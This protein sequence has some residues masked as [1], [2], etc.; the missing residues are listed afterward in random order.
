MQDPA[1]PGP[2]AQEPGPETATWPHRLLRSI[3]TVPLAIWIFL[4]EWVWDSILAL[5]RWAG[6]LPPIH[7]LE[8][9]VSK[10]PPYAAL[11]AF[12]VPGLTLLPFKFAALYLIAHGHKLYGV[13]VFIVAKLIGTA[14]LARIFSLTRPALMSI[15]WFNRAYTVF[16]HWKDRLYA[17][18]REMPSYQWMK[19]RTKALKDAARAWWRSRFGKA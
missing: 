5:M 19:A 14:F 11:I 17:Y 12:A 16:M 2:A 8:T 13:A 3:A 10:L 18:V 9:Q 15:S 7:W 6:R 4:E 1:Q